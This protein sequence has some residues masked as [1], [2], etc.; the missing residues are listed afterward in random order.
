MSLNRGGTARALEHVELQLLWESHAQPARRPGHR[1]GGR[2][3]D[4]LTGAR[5]SLQSVEPGWFSSRSVMGQDTCFR[6]IFLAAAWREGSREPDECWRTEKQATG[7][8][9]ERL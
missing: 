7:M 1:G 8:V 9:Q 6:S 4:R 2:G 3:V 5:I